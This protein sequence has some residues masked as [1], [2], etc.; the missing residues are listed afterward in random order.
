MV[1]LRAENVS[2]IYQ[3][4]YQKVQAL[5]GVT[6]DFEMGQ[7]YAITGPSGSGKTTFLSMLAGL[8]M[9]TT[10]TICVGQ[11]PKPLKPDECE[12]HRSENVSVIYQ[13]FNLF[14]TLTVLENV[15][16]PML[17]T[18][19]NKRIDYENPLYCQ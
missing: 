16:Y 12:R 7:F 2:Y 19:R 9:P 14:P 18:R 15:M 10:G 6:C 11:P 3:G 17:M 1:V 8:G 4:K 5:K 13:A